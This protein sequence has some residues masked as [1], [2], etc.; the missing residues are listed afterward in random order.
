MWRIEG[1]GVLGF[2]RIL[3]SRIFNPSDFDPAEKMLEKTQARLEAVTFRVTNAH[4]F[5]CESGSREFAKSF[6]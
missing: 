4:R 2:P 5:F 3:H 6:S 1:G